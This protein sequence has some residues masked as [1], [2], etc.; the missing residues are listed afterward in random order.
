[1]VVYARERATSRVN[2][3]RS[4]SHKSAQVPK[5]IDEAVE[6]GDVVGDVH[7]MRVDLFQPSLV[8]LCHACE[9]RSRT[10]SNHHRRRQGPS[11]SVSVPQYHTGDNITHPLAQ[12]SES[13]FS[14]TCLN[15]FGTLGLQSRF[16][17]KVLNFYSGL[18]PKRG[19]QY[20]K[21]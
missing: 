16:G 17:D 15:P 14:K 18:P 20:K 2:A 11:R 12:I 6:V 21:G 3:V 10:D 9:V 4:H 5:L 13:I 1:M 19:L 7:L 8:H